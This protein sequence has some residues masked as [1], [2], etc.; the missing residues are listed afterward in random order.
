[1]YIKIEHSVVEEKDVYTVTHCIYS[2]RGGQGSDTYPSPRNDIEVG[3]T[4]SDIDKMRLNLMDIP[5]DG[6]PAY[7]E[8]ATH[9]LYGSVVWADSVSEGDT[10]KDED[11]NVYTYTLSE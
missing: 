4:L 9:M 11:G 8:K 10:F 7:P 3:D 5:E 2:T 6:I 1:M